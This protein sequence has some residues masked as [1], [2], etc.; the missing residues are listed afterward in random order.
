MEQLNLKKLRKNKNLTQVD[1]A[2]EL[3]VSQHMYSM[4]ENDIRKLSVKYAKKLGALYGIDWW[5]FY[6]D[7]QAE[8]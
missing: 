2:K 6:A 4:I 7:E 8:G 1:V 5:L 3:G